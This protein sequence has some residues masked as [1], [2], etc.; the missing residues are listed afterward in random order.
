MMRSA[1]RSS[2]QVL[3]PGTIRSPTASST[4]WTIRFARS[5][6]S[7]SPGV[8]ST[9]AMRSGPGAFCPS[10]APP[11]FAA[12]SMSPVEMAGTP[13]CWQ[14]T[15]PC[16]PLPAPGG[17]SRTTRAPRFPELAA[18][19][20]DPAPLH[21]PLV[22]AHHELALD[23]LDGVHR[24]THHDQQR[25]A[26]EVEVDAHALQEPVRQVARHGGPDP[27]QR[28]RVEA[29][30]QELR[31]QADRRQIERANQVQPGQD[32]VDILLRTLAGRDDGGE[33]AVLTP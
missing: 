7:I 22:V 11:A 6:R 9:A 15:C 1:R 19:A 17:P 2:S 29:G 24:H 8:L 26:A 27:G 16:I 30:E 32:A 18:S 10:G 12:R 25:R 14:S 23:L 20:T 21:E 13:R 33:P 31:Q 28:S 5:I 4:W 3:T